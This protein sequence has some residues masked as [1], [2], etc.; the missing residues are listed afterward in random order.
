MK[1]NCEYHPTRPAH[2]YCRQ[3]NIY[4]CPGCIIHPKTADLS[5]PQQLC[6]KCRSSVE[7]L[8]VSNIIEPFWH[9]LP[10]IFAYPL[11]RSPLILSAVFAVISVMVSGMGPIQLLPLGIFWLILFKY[12]FECLKTTAKG[13]L[14]APEMTPELMLNEISPVF[15]Q[16]G[17]YFVPFAIGGFLAAVSGPLFPLIFVPYIIFVLLLIP[18]MI[19]LLVTTNSLRKAL[20]PVR[21][22]GLARRI[23][24]GYLL[25]YFFLLLL[26]GAPALILAYISAWLP[27]TVGLMIHAF[28]QCFY[29]IIYYHLMGYVLLQYHEKV[30]Y[31]VQ[32]EDFRDPSLERPDLEDVDPGDAVLKEVTPLIQEARFDE[33]IDLIRQMTAGNIESLKLSERYYKL[34]KMQ[35]RTGDMAEHGVLHLDLLTAA[36]KKEKAM[37][38][39][40]ECRRAK[41]DFLPGAPFLFKLGEWLNGS[42]KSKDALGAYNRL[43]KAHPADPLAPKACFRAAQIFHDRFMNPEKARQI[44]NSVIQKYPGSEIEPQIRNYMAH[45]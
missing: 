45:L 23:G 24:W 26:T 16:V 9:R 25:M 21:F 10:K 11:S 40:S 4:L 7:W 30:G 20:N 32:F 44:L 8:G 13:D 35:K 15:K 2:W 36:G 29:S 27:E 38:V 33:A 14:K 28:A 31:E 42:G 12:S 1:N 22:T 6:P 18:S 3:C 19:I 41:A 37:Q 17:V 39:Y 5:D 34:L 43:V